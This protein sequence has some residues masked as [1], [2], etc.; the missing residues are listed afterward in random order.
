MEG[1]TLVDYAA[2][3]DA[4]QQII[5]ALFINGHRPSP[6]VWGYVLSIAVHKRRFIGKWSFWLSSAQPMP[7]MPNIV[8]AMFV[9]IVENNQDMGGYCPGTNWR[10]IYQQVASLLQAHDFNYPLD[11]TIPDI[12][13]LTL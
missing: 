4:D 7:R 1:L 2:M 8:R 12:E 3:Q 5:D 11:N 10:T 6:E 9:D 13:R